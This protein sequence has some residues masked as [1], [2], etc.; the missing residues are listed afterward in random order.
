LSANLRVVAEAKIAATLSSIPY[1]PDGDETISFHPD[2]LRSGIAAWRAD[3]V[4]DSTS[5]VAFMHFRRVDAQSTK[6]RFGLRGGLRR[7]V[8]RDGENLVDAR[9]CLREL[10]GGELVGAVADM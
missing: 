8:E 4:H 3:N 2:L 1:Q 7:H 9:V 6:H 5:P 10:S